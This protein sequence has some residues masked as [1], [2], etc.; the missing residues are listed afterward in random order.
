MLT[1]HKGVPP[2]LLER[3]LNR[4]IK[5]GELVMTGPSPNTVTR[6]GAADPN[7]APV[8]AAIKDAAT[9]RAIA[10][11]PAL[12]A[13]EA[14][15]DGR[16]TIENDDI[17]GLLDLVGHNMRWDWDNKS[18]VSLWRNTQWVTR[19]LPRNDGTR[20]KSNVAHHYDLSD[21][22]YDLFLDADRQYS[23]AYF[24]DRDNTLETAQKD[25]LAHRGQALP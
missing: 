19:L 2:M 16:L 18:R 20:A 6:Y 1:V 3:F 11:S 21:R 12:G 22:L 25:K 9:S 24:T 14:W 8:H 13:G 4:I 10:R 17:L 7:R 15:M 5:T 23:C